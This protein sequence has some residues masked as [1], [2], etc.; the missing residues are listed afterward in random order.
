MNDGL[1]NL[2]PILYLQKA[3]VQ[4][5]IDQSVADLANSVRRF[6]EAAC[7]LIKEF[8]TDAASE[9]NLQNFVK[10]CR[11]NCSGNLHWRCVYFAAS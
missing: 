4:G 2:I 1:D 3:S 11:N 8:R 9:V 10:G 7:Q 6:D 5:A